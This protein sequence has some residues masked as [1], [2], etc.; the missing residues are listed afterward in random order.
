MAP[1]IMMAVLQDEVNVNNSCRHHTSYQDFHHSVLPETAH[2]SLLNRP[3]ALS[4][5][6]PPAAGMLV[7]RAVSSS[8][9]ARLQDGVPFLTYHFSVSAV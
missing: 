6:I 4:S 1:I 7:I 9:A 5:A 8:C 2:L 3:M